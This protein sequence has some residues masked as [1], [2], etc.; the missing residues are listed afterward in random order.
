MKKFIFLFSFI[1]SSLVSFNLLAEQIA[2]QSN[3]Q[4]QVQA[5]S[6]PFNEDELAQMLAPIALYPDSLLTHILIAAT[7]P[8]EIVEAD[9]WLKKNKG[10]STEDAAQSVKDF[11]WDASVKALVPFERILSRLSEDLTWT[12]Q[13]GDAFLQDESRLLESI[14]ELRKQAQLAGNLE[15]MDNMDVSYEDNNIVIEPIEKEI[16]YVP[17]YDTRMVYGTWHSVSY[18]PV[19]WKPHH[20]VYVSRYHP[21]YYHSGIHISFNY[22]FSAFHWS[23]RH[24]VVV[25]THHYK[26]RYYEQRPRRLIVNGGYA[27]H[28]KHQPVHRKG[29]A[30]RTKHTRLKYDNERVKVSGASNKSHYTIQKKLQGHTKKSLSVVHH[31]SNKIAG[32]KVKAT[33]KRTT[34]PISKQYVSTNKYNKVRVEKVRPT[35][36]HVKKESSK[37]VKPKTFKKSSSQHSSNKYSYSKHSV[38]KH[39]SKSGGKSSS[40]K[41]YNSSH[42]EKHRSA[43][44]KSNHA[45]SVKTRHK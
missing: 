45:K 43:A 1:T 28:W 30:Y 8:I 12:Q 35:N 34:K 42:K 38:N 40:K 3:Q 4:Q 31:K 18:P 5:E 6:Q 13:L 10:L 25:N 22:F 14:Q 21:F 29:V 19:Y 7:Y 24:V 44:V 16:V 17:Y 32:R 39:S 36:A 26:H 41:K 20:N 11:N 15:K 27:K 9:R 2:E 33:S 23:N 37:K